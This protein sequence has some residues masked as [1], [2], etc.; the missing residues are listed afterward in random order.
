M[1]IIVAPKNLAE[2]FFLQNLNILRG[3]CV[4]GGVR[5]GESYWG[6]VGGVESEGAESEGENQRGR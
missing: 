2:I 3:R 1:G 5:G 6:R 4:G